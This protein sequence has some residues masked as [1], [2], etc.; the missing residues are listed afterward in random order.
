MRNKYYKLFNKYCSNFKS[1]GV[2]CEFDFDKTFKSENLHEG[3]WIFCPTNNKFE[4][5]AFFYKK[6]NY[7]VCDFLIKKGLKPHYYIYDNDKK[8]FRLFKYHSKK[9]TE[10]D[11]KV[12]FK[13][14]KKG[15]ARDYKS[16][17][18]LTKHQLE[19][20]KESDIECLKSFCAR[21]LFLYSFMRLEHGFIF[22]A[23]DIDKLYTRNEDIV[24][25][26]IKEKFAYKDGTFGVNYTKIPLMYLF[27]DSMYVIKEVI[28]TPE[29]PLINWL[30]CSRDEIVRHHSMDSITGSKSSFS[31][32]KNETVMI[33]RKAFSTIKNGDDLVDK[34]NI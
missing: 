34:I 3:F 16:N 2:L 20:L 26:E 27:D 24:M 30:I 18:K 28:D 17:H 6:P 31:Q 11:P 32:I 23:H 7:K 25:I 1:N 33:D 21:H 15:N 19:K 8:T 29:R 13:S 9:F 4:K 14:W 5:N 10:I 22:S 12:E